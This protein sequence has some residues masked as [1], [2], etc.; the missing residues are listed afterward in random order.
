MYEKTVLKNGIKVVTEEIPHLLSVSVGIWVRL[1]SRHESKEK[2]GIAHF[3]EHMLFKGT[4]RRSA[5]E[6]ASEIESVGG[7][8]NAFTSREYTSFYSKTLSKDLPLSMDLLSDIYLHPLFA[9]DEIAKERMV[10]LEEINLV[11]DTPDDLVHDLFVM[12]MWKDHPLGYSILGSTETISAIT[13]DDIKGYY[14]GFYRGFPIL[15][16]VC[17]KVKHRDVVKMVEEYM[18]DISY[19]LKEEETEP[20]SVQ[21]GVYVEERDLEQVHICLGFKGI[22]QGH[23]MRYAAYLFNT[24]IGGG[25][26]SRLFQEVREKRG[27]VYSIYS[28]LSLYRDAGAFTVYAG[29]NEGTYGEVITVI[30]DELRKV[31]AEGVG[32]EELSSAKEQLKGNLLLGLE[33]SENRMVKLAKDELYHGRYISP[34]EIMSRIDEVS[35]EEIRT[36]ARDTI[37]EEG[38]V[39]VLLGKAQAEKVETLLKT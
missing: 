10:I 3:I 39:L 26:S 11:R 21:P 8:L 25:M 35:P 38:M 27:L 37:R 16:T 5:R 24:I 36:F 19:P 32:E 17:G 23:P 20:P 31:A 33:S 1:G 22:P 28:Y 18:G 2:N 6:I 15:V 29:T 12:N 30:L 14:D 13:R 4:E 7:V 9:D 34:E